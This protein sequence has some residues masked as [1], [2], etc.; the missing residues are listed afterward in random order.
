MPFGAC[1]GKRLTLTQGEDGENALNKWLRILAW[2]H[3]VIGGLGLAICWGFILVALSFKDP[4]YDDEI[5][6]FAGAFGIISLSFFLPSFLSG[7]ALLKRWTW[8]RAVLWAESAMLAV[9]IPIGTVIA[10][11]NLWALLATR[12]VSAEGGIAKFED[13][14]RGSI[15]P[16]MLALIALFTLGV[17]I[18]LGYIFRDVIDP[19]KKQNVTPL[20]SGVPDTSDLPRFEYL[21]PTLPERS[22]A[23]G[24]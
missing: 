19:P 13:F 3:L 20:P 14:V 15:R 12:E 24:Q 21:P 2:S 4:A 18:G 17:M 16:V 11:I 7:L 23:P 1:A 22:G 10:G 6:F 9:L 5:A 8:A